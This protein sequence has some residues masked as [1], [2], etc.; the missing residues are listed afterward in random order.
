MNPSTLSKSTHTQPLNH[1]QPEDAAPLL[2]SPEEVS[3]FHRN[4]YHGPFAVLS[5]GEMAGVR[6]TIDATV[7]PTEGP[8]KKVKTTMRHLDKKVIYDLCTH[9]EIVGR[10]RAI[11]GPHLLLWAGT[12]WN[13]LPGG[14]E[15]PWHQD[16]NYWPIEPLINIT[17]WIAVDEVTVENACLELIPGSHKKAIPHIQTEGKWFQEE[18]DP[19]FFDASQRLQVPMRPGQCI[20][21]NEKLLHHSEPNNSQMR[22]LAIAPR[23]TIPIVRID[24]EAL[25]PGHA[26]ILVSGQDY[27]GFNRLT[28]PPTA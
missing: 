26:A 6:E 24:H 11:L 2:L 9:P 21:F 5:P 12:M 7:L 13:K 23:F 4:G 18:A 14:K 17:A 19:R 28:N 20:L 27:M 22:R 15:I 16:L 1:L 25:F 3:D 10:I 8:N